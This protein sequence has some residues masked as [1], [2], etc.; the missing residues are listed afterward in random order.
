MN[1]IKSPINY[2][3]NK[4]KLLEQITSL[5]PKKINSF[6]DVFGGGGTMSLNINCSFIH[7]N[8]IVGFIPKMLS[9][10][11][12]ETTKSALDKIH[13][14][15]KKY[16]LSITNR[17]GFEK[18]R[19]DY[20]NGDRSWQN[21]YMLMC[22][23]FNYQFRFNNKHEYNS[24]FGKDRSC[25]ST[26]TESKFIK[27]MNRLNDIDIVFKSNDF[28]EL[29]FSELDSKDLVYLDP[30]YLISTGNYND[31]KRGFNGWTEKDEYDL[32]NLLD[33]LNKKGIKFAL[34]NVLT[35]K[36]KSNDILIDWCEKNKDKYIVNH[37]NHTY[38][39]CNYHDKTGTSGVSDEV[40]I[41][42]YHK[43]GDCAYFGNDCMKDMNE[44]E[45]TM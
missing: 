32:L 5:F 41:C 22:H 12:N 36:G 42:N 39:N 23:S 16:K 24:S 10:M 27:F 18:L 31:G 40:L 17:E 37:L 38:S 2:I 30:P 29:D 9:D 44:C 28:R 7:Y 25:Y 15:I 4:Y 8:D 6:T 21:L 35:H 13:M 3:G 1:Y 45:Y 43:C 20:N 11:Q 19:D 33:D 14:V 34:S 26:T